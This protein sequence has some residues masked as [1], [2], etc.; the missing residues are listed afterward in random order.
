MSDA[1]IPQAEAPDAPAGIAA[2]ADKPSADGTGAALKGKSQAAFG[3]GWLM[4]QL[5]GPLIDRGGG[6]G[7]GH[8]PSVSG[9][10]RAERVDLSIRELENALAAA[11]AGISYHKALEEVRAARRSGTW[12]Q[13]FKDALA[14]LHRLLLVELTVRDP[15]VGRAYG[16]GRSL[17]DTAWLPTDLVSLQRQL[18]PYRVA[19]LDGWLSDLSALLGS[20]AVTAVRGSLHIWSAWA[21]D[22]FI[23]RRR[24][25]WARDGT[26]V[27]LALRR[28]GAT[29][30]DLLSGERDPASLLSA[31]AYV[32]AADTA[33]HRVG[34]LARQVLVHFWYA[35]VLLLA[36]VGGLVYLAVTY[37][38][39]TAKFWSAF[40]AAAGGFAA[41]VQ[42]VRRNLS[43]LAQRA[44]T[45]LWQVERDDA[46]QA[47]ATR[48]PAGAAAGRV[49]RRVA[50]GQFKRP[51]AAAIQAPREETEPP[52]TSETPGTKPAATSAVRIVPASPSED[53][54]A[55]NAEPPDGPA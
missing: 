6:T 48:L 23:A 20:D 38:A 19:E 52:E 40:V 13:P 41:L 4:A 54:A 45:P 42:G 8:L 18:N 27:E 29:W 24:L 35:A 16:L 32:Q 11:A 36:V 46:L 9:L 53:A 26:S 10:R 3:A 34:F 15:H 47:G 55:A 21:A 7:E 28:Q 33:V 43:N 50:P 51:A 17:S 25:N 37:A 2:D 39:G 12:H 14:I 44:E 1:G 49:R 22:P 30:R 31:D 5:Y